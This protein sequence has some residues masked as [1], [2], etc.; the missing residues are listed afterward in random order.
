MPEQLAKPARLKIPKWLVPTF[1][2][3]VA[4]AALF[5]VFRGFDY[6]QLA[7][8]VRTLR[9]GWVSLGIVLN[10]TVYI[11]D[12]WRWQILLSPAEEAPFGECT[13]AVFIGLVA[14]GLLPAK[15]GEVIRCYLL[16]FWTDTPLSLAL[17]S[18]AIGRVMDG[19]WMVLAFYLFTA[20]MTNIPRQFEDGAVA[21]SVGIALLTAMLLFVL[22]R[23][24][25]ANSF[26]SGNKWATRFTQLLMKFTAWEIGKH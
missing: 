24:E 18:D 17:T 10:L 26:V 1:G 23:R 7:H 2:Y 15:A 12:S 5:L 21:L 20:G 4:L 16:S 14:N 8:D 22:F 9:W 3:A 6:R 13:K 11:I 19:I 25:H